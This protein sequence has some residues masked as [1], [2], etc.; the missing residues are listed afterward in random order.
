MPAKNMDTHE[1]AG[2]PHDDPPPSYLY[3]I[4]QGQQNGEASTGTIW[5]SPPIIT[6]SNNIRW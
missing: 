2:V 3:A 6:W 1:S 5:K 4:E